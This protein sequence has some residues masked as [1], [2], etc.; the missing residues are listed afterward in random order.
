MARMHVVIFEGAKWHTFAPLSL[1]RPVFMLKT[2]VGTLLDKQIRHLRPTRLSLWVRPEQ[3]AYVRERVV[4]KVKVPCT[5]NEPLDDEP[6][7]LVSGRTVHFGQYEYPPHEAVCL[8]EEGRHV[9]SAFVTRPGLSPED[10]RQRSERWVKLLD[11]P[12]MMTQSRMVESLWDL[13]SWNEE[14]LVEDA[15]QFPRG[16]GKPAGPYHMI[17][18]DDVW[19]G[20]SV[21]LEPGCVLDASRGPV[22]LDHHACVGANSVVRGPCYVGPHTSIRACSLIRPGTSIGMM[23]NVGGEVSNCLILG[24]SNKAHD[25]YLGDSYV[26]KWV[27]LGAGT[28]TSNLKNTYGEITMDMGRER[29]P[30]GRRKLGSLI[31]DHT[32]TAVLTRLNTGS[33]VGFCSMVADG[34]AP[35]KFVPSLT[36]LTERGPEPYRL[37]KAIEVTAR[38]FARRDRPWTPTDE[39]MMR[40]A[41]AAAPEVEGT[42]EGMA[43]DPR[44]NDQ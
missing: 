34:G 42:G 5:V 38:V 8:D 1:S 6:A 20:A 29:V 2:G 35:P 14:S 12:Q 4:P 11:L 41:A 18:G 31:G 7:L 27:N 43:K 16:G 25:G 23:C 37:E 3:E 24:F 19:L 9:R 32:K 17:N 28:T 15:M 40:Y 30:T 26:G 21:S 10:V 44:A 13:I 36:F 22:L 39:N 33:Y